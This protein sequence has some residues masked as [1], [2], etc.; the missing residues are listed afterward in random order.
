MKNHNL[1]ISII[2]GATLIFLSACSCGHK[3]E[4]EQYEDATSGIKYSAYKTLS[5]EVFPPLFKTYN[6]KSPDSLKVQLETGRL[7]LGYFWM[8]SGKTTFGFAEGNI[9]K[10]NSKDEAFKSLAKLMIAIGMYEN[11]WKTLAT[12]ETK[13]ATAMLEKNPEG[14]YVKIEIM[15]IQLLMGTYSVYAKDFDAAKFHMAG[16]GT[17]SGIHWP[18][19]LVDAMADI[20]NGDLQT[21]LKRSKL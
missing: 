13:D 12:E 18:Y 14:R 6:S 20:E 4:R 5:K 17:M 15:M 10:E 7:V 19:M 2:F 8:C 21:G 9:I 1:F 16:F 11:G 3:T